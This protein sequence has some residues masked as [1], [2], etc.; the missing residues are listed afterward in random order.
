M[1]INFYSYLAFIFNIAVGV[2][3]KYLATST[4]LYPSFKASIIALFLSSLV[5]ISLKYSFSEVC[6][7]YLYSNPSFIISLLCI[8]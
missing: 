5:L 8:L 2:K 7:L 1:K 4:S 3:F 6:F